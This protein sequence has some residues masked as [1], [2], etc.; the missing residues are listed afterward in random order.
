MA[1]LISFPFYINDWLGS[2]RLLFLMRYKPDTVAG[3]IFLLVECYNSPD[4]SVPNDDKELAIL[5]RL[6]TKRFNRCSTDVK[7]FFYQDGDRLRNKKCDKVLHKVELNILNKSKAGLASAEKRRKQA[8][9]PTGDEQ[10]NNRCSTSVQQ[11][12]PSPKTK[13]TKKSILLP[14]PEPFTA[15]D[16]HIDLADEHGKD[17]EKEMHKFKNH[18]L[19]KPKKYANYTLAFSNWLMRDFNK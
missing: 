14:F 7:S 9:I 13:T 4:G 5:S 11:A 2:A 12:S 18:C 3:Y 8:G 1:E 15:T 19:S 16:S 17:L 6:G 10:V